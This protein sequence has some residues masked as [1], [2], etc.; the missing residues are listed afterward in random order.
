MFQT[1][2]QQKKY[3]FFHKWVEGNT[4]FG[5]R[6]D[7]LETGAMIVCFYGQHG[8]SDGKNNLEAPVFVRS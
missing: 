6:R 7:E 2:N 3:C 5:G 8:F 4:V 1:T